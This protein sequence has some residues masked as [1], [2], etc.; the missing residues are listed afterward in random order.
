MLTYQRMQ[1]A[2]PHSTLIQLADFVSQKRNEAGLTSKQLADK[3][4]LSPAY[5]SR[6]EKGDYE[7]P[8]LPTMRA[9]AEGLGLSLQNLLQEIGFLNNESRPSFQLISQ[10]LRQMG[11]SDKET[12]DVIR[13]ARY[14]REQRDQ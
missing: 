9:L 3:S 1:T 14:L 5:I 6:I 8:S 13:Y 2:K 7:N 10:S 11:Y 12:E 4:G